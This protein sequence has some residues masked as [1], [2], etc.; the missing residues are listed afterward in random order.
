MNRERLK[1][2]LRTDEGV[3]YKPYKDTV[4]K[5]T[6]GVGRNLDDRGLS[7]DEVNFLLEGDINLCVLDLDRE[8][9]WWKQMSDARQ[10]V[11]LNMCF[12]LGIDRL[13]GFQNT[14][15][16]MEA[17]RYDAA[18]GGMLQSKWA[19][20]VGARAQRLAKMMREG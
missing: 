8:L 4:G 12:N 9:P 7:P 1:A 13:L 6:I 20:Q 16:F 5:T 3:R 10:E 19:N 14:L 2:Q 11:L 17:G 18:A 15:A